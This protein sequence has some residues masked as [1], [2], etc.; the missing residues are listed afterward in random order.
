MTR[1]LLLLLT[2]L[3]GVSAPVLAEEP[4]HNWQVY[5]S[6]K[7]GAEDAVVR[8]LKAARSSVY[9]QAY[10]FT[11]AAIAKA[12]VDAHERGVTVEAILDKS[13]RKAHYS[14]ATFLTNAGIPM[15]IDAAHEIAHNKVMIIDGAT[16][17]TGSYNFTR[18]AERA[19]AENLLI[20]KD[21]ELAVRYMANW[22]KHRGH[23]Q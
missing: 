21:A 22:R 4:A 14:A 23:A 17:I 13:N 3:L 12:L 10:S 7:G 6:P 8:A 2:A 11:N 20:I 16:V 19:N 18:A 5:F 1:A 15:S 9:V